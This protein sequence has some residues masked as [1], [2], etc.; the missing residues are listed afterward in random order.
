MAQTSLRFI[1]AQKPTS[2]PRG[3]IE[4][5]LPPATATDGVARGTA[6][7]LEADIADTPLVEGRLGTC[8]GRM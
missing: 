2:R 8:R 7:V 4:G 3:P 5:S 6:A 1:S